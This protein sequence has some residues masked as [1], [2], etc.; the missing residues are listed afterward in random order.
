MPLSTLTLFNLCCNSIMET[1]VHKLPSFKLLNPT[2]SSSHYCSP[3]TTT[4]TSKS[5]RIG[6]RRRSFSISASASAVREDNQALGS[7]SLGHITRP[8]FP[9]LHQVTTR[10]NSSSS[11]QCQNLE[12]KKKKIEKAK[13]FLMFLKFA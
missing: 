7:V 3:T 11:I 8:D 13:Q 10:P 6:S 2:S 5:F 4:R 1:V 12:P 9:I